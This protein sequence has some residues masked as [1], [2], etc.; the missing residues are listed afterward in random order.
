[1]ATT[2]FIY[3]RRYNLVYQEQITDTEKGPKTT[4]ETNYDGEG[5]FPGIVHFRTSKKAE[6]LTLWREEIT[7]AEDIGDAIWK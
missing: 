3:G 7:E 1:M 6:V 4:V 5:D 2:R